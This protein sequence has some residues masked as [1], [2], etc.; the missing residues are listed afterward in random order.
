MSVYNC[1]F[2]GGMPMGNLASG[3]F[4]SMFT[5]PIVLAVNGVLLVMLA[6]YFMLVKRRFAAL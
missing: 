2:R 4:I 6:L 5:V 3:W 1:A